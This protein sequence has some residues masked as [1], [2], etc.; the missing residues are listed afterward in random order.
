MSRVEV[1]SPRIPVN[2]DFDIDIITSCSPCSPSTLSASF[3][4]E[5]RLTNA[6]VNELLSAPS[7]LVHATDDEEAESSLVIPGLPPLL[8]GHRDVHLRQ[9]VM[10][11]AELSAEGEPDAEKAFFVADISYVYQQHLRWKKNLPEIEPFYGKCRK[12]Y[13]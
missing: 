6:I 3:P 9:G 11:A 5:K 10:Q 8:R 1:L 13:S 4:R 12:I 7:H 2:F